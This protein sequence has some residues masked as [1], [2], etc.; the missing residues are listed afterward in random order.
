MENRQLVKCRYVEVSL[1][2]DGYYKN[3]KTDFLLLREVGKSINPSIAQRMLY[4][5]IFVEMS[6]Q[7]Y[8]VFK[9]QFDNESN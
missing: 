3:F 7:E 5:S 2:F 6:E 8:E 1:G 4:D 9:E